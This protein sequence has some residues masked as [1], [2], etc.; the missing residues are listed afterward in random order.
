MTAIGGPGANRN[1]M[2]YGANRDPD[3]AYVGRGAAVFRRI[4]GTF[5]ATTALPAGAATITD[6]AL[7]P[8]NAL[9]VWAVDDNQVFRSFDGGVTW[10]DVTG[11]LP[12]VSAQDFR[13]IEFISGAPGRVA[14]GTRSGV[15]VADATTDVWSLFGSALPD[16]LVFDLR[17]VA[18]QATLYAGTLGRG[19]WSLNTDLLFADGFQP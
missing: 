11:N 18:T 1:A 17:Y 5:T 4:S 16:V 14:L 10:A 7:D 19:V 15:F 13:T 6:V 3:A 8:S 12:T 9:R 2:A